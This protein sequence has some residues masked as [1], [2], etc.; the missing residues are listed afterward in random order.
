MKPEELAGATCENFIDP[1][2]C[3]FNAGELLKWFGIFDED[4]IFLI[5][6]LLEDDNIHEE[7]MIYSLCM[8]TCGL[9]DPDVGNI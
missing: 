8:E 6:I 7:T 1:T 2:L 5:K 3:A 4:T 9:C